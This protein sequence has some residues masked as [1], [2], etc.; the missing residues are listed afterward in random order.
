MGDQCVTASVRIDARPDI[1]LSLQ[2]LKQRAEAGS[3]EIGRSR[4]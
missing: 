3:R 2:R 4:R 1:L